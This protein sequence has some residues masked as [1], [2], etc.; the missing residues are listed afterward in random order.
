MRTAERN[1]SAYLLEMAAATYAIEHFH[2]L[3]KGRR[4]YL[5]TDHKP[6]MD[7]SVVHRKILNHLEEKRSEYEFDLCYMP[8]GHFNPVDYLSR[9]ITTT[10]QVC[11]LTEEIATYPVTSWRDL[12]EQDKEITA[13]RKAL[14]KTG[15]WPPLFRKVAKQMAEHNGLVGFYLKPKRGFA[16]DKRFPVLPPKSMYNMLLQQAHD[17]A[18]AGHGR[19]RQ[20]V[21]HHGEDQPAVLVAWHHWLC[22]A[23]CG[24][25]Q[26]M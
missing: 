19:P 24:A 9:N 1:Y 22:G 7:L 18:T 11:T 25:M 13:V 26:A 6:L 14:A 4:F 8:R 21:D 15:P 5:Y 10:S 23:T 12:H 2:N 20:T 17:K 16:K 3:L